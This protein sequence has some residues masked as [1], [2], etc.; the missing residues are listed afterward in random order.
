MTE[1]ATTRLPEA[2]YT[3][4]QV[5]E[6][7]RRAIEGLGIPGF[8]LMSR[9]G[10]AVFR[11]LRARWREARRITV[12]CGGGNNGGDGYVAAALAHRA[13][14]KVSLIR[15]GDPTRLRGD[16]LTAADRAREAGVDI[17]DYGGETRFDADV[18]VDA[19]LGTGLDRA[20]EGIWAQAIAAVNGS[21]CPVLAVDIPSGLQADSGA[22]PGAVVNA[23]MTVTFIGLKRGLFTGEAPEQVGRVLFHDLEVPPETYGD[24]PVSA[25]L[26]Q[27]RERF[28]Y[29]APRSRTGHKGHYGHVLVVGGNMGFQGATVLAG[30]AAARCGGGLVSLATRSGSMAVRRPPELMG[31][32]VGSADELA[33][34]LERASVVC[35]GPGLGRDD[36][37][38]SMLETVLASRHP[39]VVDADALNLLAGAP[40]RRDNWILTPHPGEAARLLRCS[41]GEVQTDRFRAL[42]RLQETLGGVV[43]LKGAGTLAGDDGGDVWLCPGGNP[44]MAGGG[45]GDV[46]TGIIGALLAQGIPPSVSARLGVWL[47]ARAGDLAARQGGERGLL[48]T[49]LLPYLRRLV[50][51]ADRG[52]AG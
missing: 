21:G 50:N 35:V 29:L 3:A 6:M 22:A 2:L 25:R 7:D 51:P 34:L 24:F 52:T 8:T 9:A 42:K 47:H 1:Y 12:L 39:L 28:R 36:W 10:T 16:A 17:T 20:V 26:E 46:L 41:T 11:A 15:L 37:A 5:R 43:V 31:H 23:D 49:D 27:G 4:Q 38:G 33:D 30:M 48:A 14:L 19:L 18:L 45:M 32:G 40:L 44:G 13:G